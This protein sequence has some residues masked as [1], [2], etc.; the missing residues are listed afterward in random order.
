[1][2]PVLVHNLVSLAWVASQVHLRTLTILSG[3]LSAT[4]V[5]YCLCHHWDRGK[6]KMRSMTYLLVIYIRRSAIYSADLLITFLLIQTNITRSQSITKFRLLSN[7]WE[8]K[9]SSRVQIPARWRHSLRRFRSLK[10]LNSSDMDLFSRWKKSAPRN[11]PL[12]LRKS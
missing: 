10:R 6:K 3:R 12:S 8:R 7:K 4:K 9:L 5:T 2:N 1:M 11:L